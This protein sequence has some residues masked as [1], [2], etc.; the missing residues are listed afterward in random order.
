M[1]KST[2]GMAI[3]LATL[4][5]LCMCGDHEDDSTLIVSCVHHCIRYMRLKCVSGYCR[6]ARCIHGHIQLD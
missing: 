3:V 5:V 2:L 1:A 6:K 4:Y